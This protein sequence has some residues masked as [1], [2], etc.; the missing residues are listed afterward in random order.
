VLKNRKTDT[1]YLV[2]L[3]TLY[4]KEDVNEDGSIKEGVV[5]GKLHEGT[6]NGVE[7]HDDYERD[8]GNVHDEYKGQNGHTDVENASQRVVVETSADDVD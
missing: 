4:L 1:V 2:V 8:G 5:A 3:F 7:A 6:A